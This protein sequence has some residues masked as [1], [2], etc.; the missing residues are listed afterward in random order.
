[1]LCEG[2]MDEGDVLATYKWRCCDGGAGGCVVI[3]TEVEV[4]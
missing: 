2:G 1:M 4:W 3:V